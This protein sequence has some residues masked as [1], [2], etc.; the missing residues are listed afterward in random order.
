MICPNCNFKTELIG[1]ICPHCGYD[2]QSEKKL[3]ARSNIFYN[4][5]LSQA[6]S[7]DISGAIDSLLRSVTLNKN[8]IQARNLLGLCCFKVGLFAD[9]LK[10]WV[11]SVAAKKDGNLASEY[12]DYFQKNSKIVEKYSESLAMY[13]TALN[14]VLQKNEDYAI[15]QLKKALEYNPDFV[16]AMNLLSF[17]YFFS[18]QKQKAA[19]LVS[20]ALALDRTNVLA[21]SYGKQLSHMP[22][23]RAEEATSAPR[24]ADKNEG[25]PKKF[26]P[27]DFGVSQ[28]LPK[29]LPFT[30]L[31]ALAVGTAAMFFIFSLM[32]MPSKIAEKDV[33]IAAAKNQNV[34][35]EEANKKAIAAKD[36]EIAEVKKEVAEA[37]AR[38]DEMTR[39]ADIQLRVARA[40]LAE[41][42][43]AAGKYEEA[44]AIIDSI[45]PD[46]LPL[47]TAGML[48]GIKS[49]AYSQLGLAAFNTAKDEYN[50]KT[51][52]TAKEGFEKALTYAKDDSVYTGDA[53]YFLGRIAEIAGDNV[54]AAAYF[55]KTVDDYPDAT[56]YDAAV[57]RYNTLTR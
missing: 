53:Y 55:K 1:G 8:N 43:H 3:T 47:S 17:C 52:D 46:G 32:I 14:Y 19:P 9:A 27:R 5:G 30:H 2:E 37:D 28:S 29:F 42:Y 56:N 16:L 18:K 35:L 39:A 45:N 10:H 33:E 22:R 26:T 44:L 12:I 21:L 13:N 34:V 15:I 49:N 24:G 48:I 25:K 20:R 7:G 41:H 40:D 54:N 23:I 57:S 4:Q 51:Y 36:A 38:Y 6:K 11:L 50:A 31:L